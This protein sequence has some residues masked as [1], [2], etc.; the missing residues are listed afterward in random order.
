MCVC[1]QDHGPGGK[2]KEVGGNLLRWRGGSATDACGAEGAVYL[3]R[4]DGIGGDGLGVLDCFGGECLDFHRYGWL[5]I[6]VVKQ[7][8]LE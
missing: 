4:R 7:S 8:C 5:G 1:V 2:C 3:V 6:L